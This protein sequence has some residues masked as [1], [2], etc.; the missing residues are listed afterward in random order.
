VLKT[1]EVQLIGSFTSLPKTAE[2]I[3]FIQDIPGPSVIRW[4]FLLVWESRPWLPSCIC[5]H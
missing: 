5:R 4:L 3:I 1:W 2:S